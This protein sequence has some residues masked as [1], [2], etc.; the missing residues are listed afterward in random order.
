MKAPRSPPP[1]PLYLDTQIESALRAR[2]APNAPF[3]RSEIRELQALIEA[4][5]P[6]TNAV[7]V[8]LYDLVMDLNYCEDTPSGRARASE[9]IASALTDIETILDKNR[10]AQAAEAYDLMRDDPSRGIPAKDVYKAIQA[11]H[12]NRTKRDR[13]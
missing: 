2:V 10:M 7:Q 3:G 8:A 11:E 6:D 1:S 9:L 5:P 13:I 4:T 12:A